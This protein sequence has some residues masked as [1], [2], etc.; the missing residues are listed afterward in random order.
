MRSSVVSVLLQACT[1]LV[2]LAGSSHLAEARCRTAGP[3]EAPYGANEFILLPEQDVRQVRGVAYLGLSADFAKDV[4]VEVYNYE[5]NDYEGNDGYKNYKAVSEV[6]KS[7]RIVACVTDSDG[8]F[9]FS[10]LRAGRY[11]LHLGTRDPAGL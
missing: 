2:G 10:G 6:L 5:G 8:K 1:V 9:S 3:D 7:R 11:L 4:V